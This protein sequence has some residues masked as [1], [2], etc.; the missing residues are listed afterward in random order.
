VYARAISGE[1]S[2]SPR[3]MGPCGGS[4]AGS[5]VSEASFVWRPPLPEA[6]MSSI[7]PSPSVELRY[8][9]TLNLPRLHL[10]GSKPVLMGRCCD[11]MIDKRAPLPWVEAQDQPRRGAGENENGARG[12]VLSSQPPQKAPDTTVRGHNS[13]SV[14]PYSI[15]DLQYCTMVFAPAAV[16]G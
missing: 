8:R 1:V 9:T 11:G 7:F 2:P 3:P 5:A 6:P 12:A 15:C 16:A 14:I 4:R 13:F 10:P